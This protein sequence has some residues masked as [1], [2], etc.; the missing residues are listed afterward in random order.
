MGNDFRALEFAPV[1]EILAYRLAKDQGVAIPTMEEMMK[2]G[3][4]E[5][6]YFNTHDE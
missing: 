3:L 6:K 2:V 5:S 4:P 1:V